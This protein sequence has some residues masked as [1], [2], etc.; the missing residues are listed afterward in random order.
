V[1]ARVLTIAGSD[2]SGGAGI[3]ADLKTFTV[4]G[5]YGMSAITALTAQN[6]LGVS[7]V[8]AVSPE[9]VR[10]QIDAVAG[11]VGIDAA[12]TGMLAN[13]PIIEA[14]AAAVR[15]HRIAPLVVDPVMVAQSG[16][17][18]LEPDARDKEMTLLGYTTRNKTL[19]VLGYSLIPLATL[20]DAGSFSIAAFMQHLPTIAE[21]WW[22]WTQFVIVARVVYLVWKFSFRT[23]MI[24][25]VKLVTD[26][27]TDVI[28][29]FP[30][31]QRA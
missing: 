28:A 20:V 22:Y 27:L 31:R 19:I 7:G 25:Y 12:K 29:Y 2:S 23:S 8:E 6:T 17:R 11:D 14:V 18:L 3:Q 4:F 21:Y 1:L 24:W 9:F 15:A 13:R 16:A 5:V 10:A 30:R 26:P